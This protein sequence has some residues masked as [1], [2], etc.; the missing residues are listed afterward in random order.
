M[1]Q[2]VTTYA[3]LRTATIGFSWHRTA[4]T[5]EDVL[6]IVLDHSLLGAADVLVLGSPSQFARTAALIGGKPTIHCY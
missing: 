2:L 1:A 5:A 3:P 6:K 4:A